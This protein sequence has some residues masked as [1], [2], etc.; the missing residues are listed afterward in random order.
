VENAVRGKYDNTD[1]ELIQAIDDVHRQVG[2]TQRQMFRLI[3]EV[4]RRGAWRDCGA[5]DLAH[6][7]GMR[8]GHLGLEG[9]PEDRRG[10]RP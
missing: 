8:Y 10:P 3:V 1:E 6:W 9:P 4:D 5:R 2:A 7:L